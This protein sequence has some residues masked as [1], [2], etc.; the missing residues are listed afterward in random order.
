MAH[1]PFTQWHKIREDPLTGLVPVSGVDAADVSLAEWTCAGV[2]T[3]TKSFPDGGITVLD[4]STA[5]GT[6]PDALA[7][8]VETDDQ[9]V[10][11][12][13]V[14]PADTLDIGIGRWPWQ[15]AV[16]G[17]EPVVVARGVLVLSRRLEPA[18]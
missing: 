17:V 15:A 18:T 11:V 2:E 16:G 8:E 13:D 1:V 7:G 9:A 14:D 10:L 3:V 5:L 12:I 6:Y 4:G